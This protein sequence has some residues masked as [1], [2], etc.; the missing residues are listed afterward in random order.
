[1]LGA[2]AAASE[3]QP[4]AC[5]D[6]AAAT[7]PLAVTIGAAAAALAAMLG[8]AAASLA[9]TVDAVGMVGMGQPATC[10][11]VDGSAASSAP[12][13]NQAQVQEKL[14]EAMA[15]VTQQ[16][17]S[18][19]DL[20]KELLDGFNV[21]KAGQIETQEA[22]RGLQVR[23]DAM[24]ARAVEAARQMAAP[25]SG[26]A[27]AAAPP[28]A[29]TPPAPK[30]EFP[31]FD[32]ENPKLWQHQ[33]EMY[34]EVFRVQPCLRTR[35]AALGFQGNAALWFQSVEATGRVE[36]WDVMCRLVHDY[37][38]KNM[39]A[40]YRHQMCALRQVGTVSE[41]WHKFA[42]L[43]QLLLY[44]PH[45]DEGHFVDEFIAGLREDIRSAIWLHRPQD[46]ETARLLA[47]LQEEESVPC[48]K[49]SYSRS[50]YK[51]NIKQK[52][53]SRN[54]EFSR[55]EPKRVD[56]VKPDDKLEALRAFRRSKGLCFTCGEKYSRTHKCPSQVSLH[57]IEELL[58]VLQIQ[59]HVDTHSNQST[60]SEDENLMLLGNSSAANAKRKRSFRLQGSIGKH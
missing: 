1:M 25:P 39:Q 53:S 38:G 42:R 32:G 36:D 44:N 16:N 33:C 43:R 46:L 13:K 9:A 8:G 2:A 15:E 57:V 55:V 11:E 24:E 12:R 48:K 47:L 17:Q 60:E 56:A 45:L 27:A 58:E 40:S 49:K 29:A 26:V 51:E 54:D 50:D 23:T 4:A 28:P 5:V 52:W 59:E 6:E 37:F 30:I 20:M 41:Y 19:T 14:Q 35:Y 7:A 31:K 10:V 3:Q 21:L 22:V 34:F 18:L